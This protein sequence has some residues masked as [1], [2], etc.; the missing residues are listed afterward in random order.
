VRRRRLHWS[1]RSRRSL[2]L[3]GLRS[4]PCSASSFMPLA[5]RWPWRRTRPSV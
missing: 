3:P 5:A 2:D 1:A 4:S